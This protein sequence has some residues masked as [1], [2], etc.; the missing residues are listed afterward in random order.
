MDGMG[1]I[2]RKSPTG[3]SF[4]Y[5]YGILDMDPKDQPRIVWEKLDFKGINN[6]IHLEI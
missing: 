2:P 4:G 6:N 5:W 1:P 3:P